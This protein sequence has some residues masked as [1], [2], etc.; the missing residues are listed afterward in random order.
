MSAGPA[1]PAGSSTLGPP[2]GSPPADV[3]AESFPM[4]VNRLLDPADPLAQKHWHLHLTLRY[5][6]E[7]AFI[8]RG[9]KPVS[10]CEHVV[11]EGYQGGRSDELAF[12][13]NED[14]VLIHRID[15]TFR[16]ETAA[17]RLQSMCPEV[18]KVHF[19]VFGVAGSGTFGTVFVAQERGEEGSDPRA[20]KYVAVKA[21][22][23]NT[24]LAD[25]MDDRYSPG[26][27]LLHEKSEELHYIPVEAFILFL[28]TTSDRFPTLD[29][30]YVH[31]QYQAIVMSSCVDITPDMDPNSYP[32]GAIFK[33]FQGQ[34]L[35][36]LDHTPLL[37]EMEA[38]KVASHLLQGML[39]LADMNLYHNDISVL[40][41]VVGQDLSVTIFDVANCAFGFEEE[42]Y[43]APWS[44][45]PFQEYQMAPELAESLAHV[46]WFK[47]RVR[48]S[49]DLR[50]WAMW[51]LGV[52]IYGILH[53][54]WPWDTERDGHVNLLDWYKV[55]GE[56]EVTRVIRRRK[57]IMNDPLPLN[58]SLSQD[59]KD[60]LQAMLAK[61]PYDRPALR[62]LASNFPWFR[63]WTYANR[64]W[65]RPFSQ[66][67][68]NECWKK[69]DTVKESPSKEH[70]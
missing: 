24:L 57:R 35:I 2:P 28:L 65:R 45:L 23:H 17:D 26:M 12:Q 21:E 41:F 14:P 61:N 38:C 53:G 6:M 55:P 32:S 44:Y 39:E 22:R 27:V 9:D 59:C 70:V 5:R 48:Y 19:Q 54:Y 52:I 13:Q 10:R 46:G 42:D 36:N 49:D 33:P 63:Q 4:L 7:N 47:K 34:Y 1:S 62:E 31:D 8:A 25:R 67:F 18:T 11:F 30:V 66:R 43:I 37:D 51:K 15:P 16:G 56:S 69:D 68:Y 58:E 60:V 64:V 29:S 40:N 50:K 3:W 20:L